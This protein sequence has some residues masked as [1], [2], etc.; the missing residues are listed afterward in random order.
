MRLLVRAAFAPLSSPDGRRV[1]YVGERRLGPPPSSS[2]PDIA[3]IR[4]DGSEQRWLTRDS[5]IDLSP[6]WS[7]DGSQVAFANDLS[8]TREWRSGDEL[9]VVGVD[10]RR[11]RRLTRN[12]AYD[13]HPAF[14]PAP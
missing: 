14:S 13:I 5:G 2:V 9:F 11:R 7:A 10:G 12:E 8:Y 6:T 3:V 1:V 4:A